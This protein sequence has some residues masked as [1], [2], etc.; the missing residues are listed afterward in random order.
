MLVSTYAAGAIIERL[1]AL[2]LLSLKNRI[3]IAE[4]HAALIMALRSS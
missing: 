1:T 2:L 4:F 3:I